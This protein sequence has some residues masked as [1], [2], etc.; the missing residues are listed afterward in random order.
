MFAYN[1]TSEVGVAYI[2]TVYTAR[3]TSFTGI[4]LVTIRPVL[5]YPQSALPD[6]DSAGHTVPVGT[7]GDQEYTSVYS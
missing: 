3:K 5:S 4:V 2:F 6:Y 7:I 1:L